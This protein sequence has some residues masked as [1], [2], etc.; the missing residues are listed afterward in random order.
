MLYDVAVAVVVAVA[1]DAFVVADDVV[2]DV[3]IVLVPVHGADVVADADEAVVAAAA[4]DVVDIVVGVGA[5]G[6]AHAHAHSATAA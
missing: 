1:D 3:G 6:G 4:D 2:V 5:V